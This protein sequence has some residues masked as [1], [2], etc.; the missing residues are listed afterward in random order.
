MKRFFQGPLSDNGRNILRRL[1]YAD[2][3]TK[4]GQISYTKRV[5]GERFPRY[6]VYIEE[7]PTGIQINLHLD[8]KEASYEG[9]SAHAGEYDGPLVEQEMTRITTFI[10]TLRSPNISLSHPSSPSTG[11]TST[12]PHGKTLIKKK[13][14][15]EA[16]FG[17]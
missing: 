7:I 17:G 16:L 10:E 14:F 6:H 1:S 2:Q 3:R 11:T 8:Q 15:W 12:K 5:T 4:T 13:G 9:T